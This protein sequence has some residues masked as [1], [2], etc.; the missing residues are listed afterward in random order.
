MAL[1]HGVV[2]VAVLSG[3]I[4]QCGICT[5]LSGSIAQCSSTEWLYW[6]PFMT[7]TYTVYVI[8][9]PKIDLPK[10]MLEF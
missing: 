6:I 3:S 5:V 9:H 4:A 2:Y 8:A 10:R 7:P 1:S